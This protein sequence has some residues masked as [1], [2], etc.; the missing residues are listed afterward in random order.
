MTKGTAAELWRQLHVKPQGNP[1]MTEGRAMPGALVGSPF[2]E[3]ASAAWGEG[4]K[5]ATGVWDAK[6]TEFRPTDTIK[7]PVGIWDQKPKSPWAAPIRS[8]TKP[9]DKPNDPNTKR[10][11]WR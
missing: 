8:A 3:T 7:P 10:A 4:P 11:P 2:R 1:T 5:R 9:V 6:A